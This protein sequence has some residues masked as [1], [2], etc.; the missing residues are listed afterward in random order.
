MLGHVDADQMCNFVT[1]PSVHGYKSKLTP[2]QIRKHFPTD[3]PDCPLGNL[4]LRHPPVV[5]VPDL[6][7]NT[8]CFEIDVKGKWMDANGKPTKTFAGQ[9]YSVTA[10][11]VDTGFI[12]VRLAKSRVSLVDHLEDLRLFTLESGKRLA[13]IR[14]DNEFLS[15]MARQWAAQH[16]I[17]FQP[18]SPNEH[19]TVRRVERVHR[20]LQEMVVK[21]LAHKSHLNPQFWGFAYLHFADLMNILPSRDSAQSPY[22]LWYGKPF[23]AS[24]Q[25]LLPFG[26]VVM[27]HIPLDQQ[28]SLS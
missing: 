2:A 17:S 19:N 4:Q 21:A 3:C 25:P 12:F 11:D 20:T 26:S 13:T 8:C 7:P 18:S 27:S 24:T 5:P 9:L 10:V 23:D 15:K 22:E 1:S 28:T 14:T 16:G 6:E